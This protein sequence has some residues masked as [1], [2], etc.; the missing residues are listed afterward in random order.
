MAI[1][2]MNRTRRSNDGS[3][4]HAGFGKTLTPEMV[5]LA[6]E[7]RGMTQKD[8][9]EKLNISQ[10]RLSK[11]EAGQ[12]PA[13]KQVVRD[14]CAHLDYPEGFFSQ[15]CRVFGPSTSEFY[16][17]KRKATSAREIAR[18]HAQINIRTAHVSRLLKSAEL[19][20]ENFPRLDPEEF[21][22]SPDEIARAMRAT[23]HLPPGP[24]K[25]VVDT[26]EDAGGIVVRFPFGTRLIDAVSRWIPGMPPMFFV[27]ESIPPDRERLTLAHEIGHLVMHQALSPNIEDEANAFAAEFLMPAAEIRSQLSNL[28]IHKLASL[29]PYWRVSM[30]ALLR[31]GADLGTITRGQ[32]QY[33]WM[34]ISRMGYRTREPAELDPPREIP[35]T[36]QELLDLHTTTLGFSAEQMADLAKWNRPELFAAYSLRLPGKES[37]SSM[38]LVK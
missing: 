11:I 28:T 35:Q 34:Q 33:L 2:Q 3:E 27:N 29:K 1:K 13:S 7:S 22:G 36:L 16:H 5:V 6:R 24:V 19:E 18:I 9:A 30:Q 20:D 15:E 10:G 23:W 12:S 14:L 17:R 32:A 38:R 4:S 31:R 25:S 8:L 21:G 37:P 26:L